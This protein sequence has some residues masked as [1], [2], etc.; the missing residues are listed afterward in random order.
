MGGGAA[1][2]DKVAGRGK[3][4][5]FDISELAGGYEGAKKFDWHRLGSP[6]Q[7][8]VRMLTI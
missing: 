2:E 6:K 8:R 7:L 1:G 5:V 3:L 4:V